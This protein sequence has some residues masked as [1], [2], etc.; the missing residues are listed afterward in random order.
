M[1]APLHE[2]IK[3]YIENSRIYRSVDQVC[4][5]AAEALIKEHS[6]KDDNP[7]PGKSKTKWK[8]ANISAEHYQKIQAWIKTGKT[9]Y[10]SVDE[11]IRSQIREI[12]KPI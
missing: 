3:R 12:I 10:A 4:R 7:S 2:E 9:P 8:T 5:E 11:A 6:L 1:P